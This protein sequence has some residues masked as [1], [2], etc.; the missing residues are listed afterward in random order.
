MSDLIPFSFENHSIR[1]LTDDNG[2]PLFVAKDVATALGYADTT[3]AIKQHCRGV[4]EYH[5]IVDSLG[6]KQEARVIREPDLYRLIANSQLP[7]AEAFEKLV[8]EEILPTIRKT[9]RYEAPNAKPKRA[10][11]QLAAKMAI[12]RAAKSMLRMSETS[13][14]RM[15][16]DIAKS[17]GIEPTFLP[18]YVNESLTKA[19]TN[20][21]K[22]LDHPLA[23][24]VRSIVHPAFEAMGILEHASRPSGSKPG[25]VR[26]FWSLTDEGLKYGRNET[27]PNNPRETIPLYF[28]DKFGELLERL[29][30]F[31]SEHPNPAKLAIIKPTQTDQSGGAA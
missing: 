7:S 4:A 10:S 13:T 28:V 2:E 5:P 15:L 8:F 18:A 16:A 24:K 20:M 30:S 25:E 29:E 23:T 26:R 12:A 31:L 9:G 22:D 17:E 19:L 21:L 11:S 27:S 1:V 6:R 14:I 3:N